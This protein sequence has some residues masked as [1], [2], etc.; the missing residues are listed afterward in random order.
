M[1]CSDVPK[2]WIRTVACV[3]RKKSVAP[4]IEP[5]TP[6]RRGYFSINLAMGT[7]LVVIETGTYGG[8]TARPLE[9]L[10]RSDYVPSESV[11]ATHYGFHGEIMNNF[12]ILIYTSF[13]KRKIGANKSV[14]RRGKTVTF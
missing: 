7:T 2:H 4:G 3:R 14:F 6:H 10:T 5:R 9:P 13:G 8:P 1:F 12:L 11:Q